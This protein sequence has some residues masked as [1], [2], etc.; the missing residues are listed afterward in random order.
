MNILDEKPIEIKPL[1]KTPEQ[2]DIEEMSSKR[3]LVTADA[4]VMSLSKSATITVPSGEEITVMQ[5]VRNPGAIVVHLDPRL[6]RIYGTGKNWTEQKIYQQFGK[7]FHATLQ[8][9]DE[10]VNV[11]ATTEIP[12]DIKPETIEPIKL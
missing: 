6:A 5:S 7:Q 12:E 1:E 4:C 10:M 9:W 2:L 8:A 11:L 3:V